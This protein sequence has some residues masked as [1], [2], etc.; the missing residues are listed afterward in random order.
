METTLT[1]K[2]VVNCM[3]NWQRNQWAKA[4]YKGL[5]KKDVN[6]PLKYV[7]EGIIRRA[8]QRKADK[9]KGIV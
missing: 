4:G 6:G 7:S 2:E 3:T 1:F 9:A 8:E 5:T